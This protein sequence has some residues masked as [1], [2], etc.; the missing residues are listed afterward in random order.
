M[1]FSAAIDYAYRYRPELSVLKT[2]LKSGKPLTD[3]QYAA[4]MAA[5]CYQYGAE[6]HARAPRKPFDAIA[7]LFYVPEY[8]PYYSDALYKAQLRA[9]KVRDNRSTAQS[10]RA[11][12]RLKTAMYFLDASRGARTE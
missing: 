9:I 4:I 6:H 10:A 2:A 5:E 7:K 3:A 1:V 12:I 11:L 8:K